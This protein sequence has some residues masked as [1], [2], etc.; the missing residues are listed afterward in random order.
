MGRDDR[1]FT[2]SK[3]HINV[4]EIIKSFSIKI[5]FVYI[6]LSFINNFI[7]ANPI[8]CMTRL[9]GLLKETNGKNLVVCLKKRRVIKQRMIKVAKSCHQASWKHKT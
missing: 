2:I 6:D 1:K 9:W 3:Y 7:K 5:F 8:G 4:M